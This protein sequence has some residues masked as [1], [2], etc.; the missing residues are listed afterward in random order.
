MKFAAII[1][2]ETKKDFVDLN[3][4]LK[5]FSLPQIFYFY[6]QKFTESSIFFALKSIFYFDDSDKQ[7]MP[8][9]F[10][11]IEW[12]TIKDNVK[13]PHADYIIKLG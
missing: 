6:L 11:K 9:M 1:N 12:K 10:N 13:K 4:L 7:E 5:I 8:F 3:E 2:R